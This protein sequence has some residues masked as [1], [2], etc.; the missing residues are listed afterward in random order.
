M[1]PSSHFHRSFL[2]TPAHW[3][4]EP[5]GTSHTTIADMAINLTGSRRSLAHPCF[6]ALVHSADVWSTIASE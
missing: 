5:S 6:T 2:P 3:G 1:T 4:A